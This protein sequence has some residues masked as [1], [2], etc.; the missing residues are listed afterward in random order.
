MLTWLLSRSRLPP[1][2]SGP[3]SLRAGIPGPRT[4]ASRLRQCD[5]GPSRV[6][7]GGLQLQAVRQV[8][9]ED[10]AALVGVGAVE[11]DHDRSVDLHPTEGGDDAVGHLFTL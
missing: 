8:G 11:A 2:R 10:L 5:R 6:E 1:G 4:L 3:C 7:H 9:L